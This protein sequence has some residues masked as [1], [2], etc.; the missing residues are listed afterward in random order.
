MKRLVHISAIG[1]D[2]EA[3][4]R[5]SASKGK[6]EEAVRHYFPTATILRPSVVFGPRD[7]FFNK[8]AKLAATFPVMPVVAGDSKFQPIYVGDVASAIVACLG[9]EATAGKN[10]EIGGPE[11]ISFRDLLVRTLEEAYQDIPLVDI[12]LPLAKI[13]AVF[14]GLLPNPVLTLD[15]VRLLEKDTVVSA[16]SEGL[17]ALGVTATP[18]GAVLSSYMVPYRPKGQ[19]SVRG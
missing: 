3:A 1:A 8:F 5:Y 19:F 12:P 17:E 4:S 7:N 15:Q 14:L 13:Q 18:I 9:D 11:V 10:Y 2:P 16:G 6:G